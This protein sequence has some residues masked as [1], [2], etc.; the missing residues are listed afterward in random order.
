M[1]FNNI[2][3]TPKILIF[4]TRQKT[5]VLTIKNNRF[6]RIKHIIY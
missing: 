1:F 3:L 2:Y 4:K 5:P 6:L